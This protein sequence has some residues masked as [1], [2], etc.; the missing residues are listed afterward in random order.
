[1]I[2]VPVIGMVIACR[3]VFLP[4]SGWRFCGYEEVAAVEMSFFPNQGPTL[5]GP[6]FCSE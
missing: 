6:F 2:G 4:H 5:V 1:M 3:F